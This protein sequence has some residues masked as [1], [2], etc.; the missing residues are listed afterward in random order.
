MGFYVLDLRTDNS[1]LDDV[2]KLFNN[3]NNNNNPYGFQKFKEVG[4]D[5]T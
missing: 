1:L 5:N 4:N 3:N 2:N